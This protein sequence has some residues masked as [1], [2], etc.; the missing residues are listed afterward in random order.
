[1]RSLSL[2]RPRASALMLVIMF[3]FA[4][5]ALPHTLNGWS[6]L[7]DTQTVNRVVS[8]HDI[9]A[10][11]YI[12]VGDPTT[13]HNSSST[14][15]LAE[16]QL[17][18]SRLLLRFPMN[19]SA[20]DTIHEASIDLECTTNDVGTTR[21]VAYVASM[22]RMWNGSYA[23]WL[24]HENNQLWGSMGADGSADRGDWE[25]PVVLAS[26]GTLS[27]NVTSLAQSAARSNSS[28]LSVI[29]A[30]IGATYTCE[31]SESTNSSARPQL[32]LDTSS[33]AATSGG[34]V[35][36]D[37][38]ID[39]GAPWMESDFLLTPVTTPTLSYDSNT[40]QDVEIQ[41][42][43]AEDWRSST[44]K[45]WHFSTLWN[46]F[47]TSGATGS[48]ALPSSLELV[49]GTTMHMRVRSV[50]S[51]DQWGAWQ[52]TS[53]LL[54][55]LDVV[56]NGDGTATMTLT[57]SD[58][59]LEQDFM[60]DATVNEVSK[61]ITY[62][63]E[64]TTEASM[65]SSK[66]RLIHFRASLNQLGLHDNLTIVNAELELTRSSYSGDP[67]VS[68]HGMEESGL[69]VEN[70][71][72]WNIMG[73]NGYQWYDGG[74][75]NGTATV[76]LVDGNQSSDT[77]TFDLDHA[78][79][80]YLDGG[81]DDPLDL[82]IAVRGKYESYTNAEGIIFHSAET[83][84][85]GSEPSFSI[86]YEWGSG[87]PPA[88]VSLTAPADGL[89]I[90]N[91]TGHNLSANTQPSLNWSQP[92]SGDDL[93]FELATDEDFR[94]REMRVDTRVDNDFSPSDGILNMTGANTLEVGNMYFWRMATVDA[95]GHYGSW[96]SS[97]FLIS[98]LQST[99]LGGDRYEFRL[100]HGNGS[101]DN[102]Y[103]AC[104]DTYIDS[105]ATSDNFDGDTEMT[106][107]YNAMGGEI[108][109]LVGCNLVSNLLPN[110][111]AVESAHL[112]LTLTSS[113]FGTPTIA[114][115]ESSQN[116]WNAEDATWSSYDGSNSWD[117]AGAKGTERGSLL[118]S[119]SVG[120]SYNEG[121]VVDW[122]VTL[123]VQNAMR[124]D[125]R[126]DFIVGMLGVGSGGSRTAYFST[127]EDSSANRP[128]LTFVY[129]PG[130]DAVPNNP[131][132]LTPLNGSW[133]L[134]SGVDLTPVT[135]PELQWNF[136]GNMSIGGYLVQLDK[137]SDFASVDAVT[138]AS[139]NDGGFDVTNLTF[140][141]GTD[142][143]T[144][145]TWYWRV[146]AISTTNQIGN[147]S[148]TFHFQVPD[149][150][151]VVFNSTKAS[152]EIEHH[153]ALP[154][155]NIPHFTDT[156]VMENG[157]GA[158]STHEN[159][160]T[161]SIGETS[162]GYQ[163][164]ALL[165][166]PLSDIPQPS[167]ARVTDAE[168]SVFAEYGS[169]VGETVAAR[170]I[171]RNWT[172]SANASTYDGTN[173]WS[174]LGGRGIGT[175]I[176]NFVD[177]VDSVSDGW[178]D[179]DITEAVQAALANGQNHVSIMLYTSSQTTDLI[180]IT[181]TEGSAS[182]RPYMTLTWEDGVVATPTVS[183]VNTGPANGA[184]V[185][186]TSSHALIA[187]RTPTFSWTYSGTTPSSAWR[188]FLQADAN[189]DM[190]GLYVFDS[191]V[192]TTSFDLT[193][194]TFTPASDITFAQEIR[195]MVQPVNNGMLGPRSASTN[196]YLPSDLGEEINATH[197]SLSIQEGGFVPSLS[198]PSVTQDTYLDSGTT[199]SNVGSSSSLYVGLSSV[200]TS[201][202]NL[203]STSLISID[204]S[205]LPMPSVYE[206]VDA[207]L[208][209]NAITA[210]QNT[211][212]T[213]SAMVSGWTESSTW[214]YPA[215]NTTAWLG[216]GAFH[217]ADADAPFNEGIWVNAT[218]VA[219][220]NVTALLQH[221]LSSGQSELN[222]I[223]QPEDI[224]GNPGRV[225][226]ASSEASTISVRPRLNITYS[227][228]T[229][230]TASSPTN[231][232]PL[233]G[234]TLWDTTKPR[235]SGQNESDYNWS[236]SYSNQT[237][238]VACA[239]Y[240]ARMVDGLECYSIG[241]VEDGDVENMSFDAASL[242]LTVENQSKGDF[243]T[244]WR[245]RA[246]Q[247][248]RI[249]EW[250]SIYKFRIPE[251]QGSDD[252]N[253]NHT[254]NLSRGSIFDT[255]G[256]LPSIP[257]VE[258]DSNSS[259]NKGSA[260]SMVLGNNGLG[261]GE[262]RIL[263]E[264]DLTNLPWPSA[265]T[266]TQMMLKL[267][268]TSVG[269]TASTTIGVYPCSSFSESTVVWAN[270]P[271]CS[272]TEI[273]RSTL[274][275]SSPVGWM[276]WDIT[277]LAQSNLANGN[278][279]M[280]FMLQRIGTTGSSH[281]F[282]T[283]D[284]V[285]SI[286]HPHIVF[287]YVDNVNGIVPPAQPMLITP[288]DGQVLYDEDGGLLYPSTQ[289]VLTWSPVSGAT[290]YIVTIANE[291]G[292]YKYKSWEDSE[293]TNTTF[294]FDVNLTAGQM[295]TWWVQGVNQTIP[296]PS[297]ARWSFAVGDPNHVNNN[298]YTFTYTMQ[299]GNE[300]PAYGHTNIQ[301]TSLVSEYPDT[302]FVGDGTMATGTY[303][304]TLFADECRLTIGLNAAQVPFP[305][306]QQ[307][308][309]AS[310]GLYVEDWTTAAGATSISFSVYPLLGTTWTQTSA[311]W[312]GT[313]GGLLWGAP[314]LQAG[315][316]Y[317]DAVS[318]T[319][320]NTNTPGWLWFDIS[321][322]GMTISSQQAW[323]IIATPNNGYAHASFYSSDATVQS[324]RP[325]ILFNT[326]NI[327]TLSITPTG[328]VT[329]DADTTVNFNSVAYDHLSMVQ[330]PPVEWFTTSGSIG[331]NGLFTPTAAGV[332]TVSAC[333]GLV[334]GEQNVTVTPGAPDE[335]LVT[336]VTATITADETLTITASMVDQHGNPVPGEAITFTP[337]NGSMSAVMP[338]V[339]Q[340]YA[341]GTHVVRVQHTSSGEF[342][343][344]S[345]TVNPGA[346]DRFD[347]SGCAGT[348]PAGVWCDITAD[349]YDQFDN[350]LDIS[351]AGNLTWTT[352][353]GNYSEMNQQYFPDHVG[354]W[355][356]NLSSVSGAAASL[357]ITVGHGQIAY[358]ELNVSATSITADDRVYI[359]TTRV[360]V[361]GN[362]L[363]VVL[364]AD[365]WT[366]IADGQLNPGAPAIWDP[367]GQG[368]KVLEARYETTLASVT[369]TVTKGAIQTLRLEVDDVISTWQHFDL[370]ADE[371]L[372]AEV[373]AID[374]KGNQWSIL[375][376]WSLTHPTMGD[377][378]NF[379]EVLVGDATTFTPY[380]ASEDHYTLTASFDDG[381]KVHAVSIN[382]TVDHGFL[383]TVSIRGTANNPDATTGAVF[384]MTA[385]YAVDFLSD[386]YDADN[387][388]IDAETLTWL[389]VN[390]ATGQTKDITTDLLLNDMRWEATTVGEWTIQAYSISGT[391]F[392]ISDSI[393][394]TVLHGVAVTVAAD[395]SVTTPTA[396][397]RV[398]ILVTGTDSDG[399]QFAQNV[400]WTENGGTVPTLNII[401][402]TDG[403]YSYDAEVAG[404]HTL[405]YAAGGATST[406]EITV[407]AQ[408]TVARLEVNLSRT[409]LEQL[410]SLDISIRAFDAFDNE[411]D[412]P[413]SVKVD[414]T[415]R[416]TARMVASNEWTVTTLDD[417]PQTITISVG[418]V[419][420]NEE[421]NVVG[422]F[423]GFFEAGGTLYYVGA[424]LLALVAVVLLVLL[425]MFMRSGVDDD[426]DDE[427]DDDDD[428][429][430]S[431]PSGPAP[432]PSGPAP[433]PSGPAPGPS[434]PAPGPSGP[435]A[436]AEEKE[437]EEEEALETSFD[438]DGTEWWEDEDGTWWYREQGVEEWQ[439][440][441][442]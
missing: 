258:I 351:A 192:N 155:L 64:A 20:S 201:N 416:G 248:T 319:V 302:N 229:P 127:A 138:Y 9:H 360:D 399:N 378:S 123:A 435:P 117:T 189:N 377:S 81:D 260:T 241:E 163:A 286:F 219:S 12:T 397:D 49:N 58:T 218:G 402:T 204:F 137:Q 85:S 184:L 411:I 36:P 334:C 8:T 243:W 208:D 47:S 304:G 393:T 353:N 40:G 274:T 295:F 350:P 157:T 410:E 217:S 5:L 10:D 19:F 100:K 328:T 169:V 24:A 7:E 359:N 18:D 144:G 133:S 63:D 113:T 166:I 116:N 120:S 434:G 48:Y 95:D 121:D 362:R 43:N 428:G 39:D 256:L 222:I 382:M 281:T 346:P 146:R 323:V 440:Y 421:I 57:P 215:G 364:P 376:N 56:D 345:V 234:S 147:W 103:P 279:T 392:N 89:A 223:L 72:T 300:I 226:F 35:S 44:D 271:T 27:L 249:G 331:S 329:T 93:L 342:V 199:Q 235:P 262:S 209:L 135:R 174:S 104:M 225:Q 190:A 205:N 131:T 320:Y 424:A 75:S 442:E 408:N 101:L 202:T 77:F 45:E 92:S 349:L 94:L 82:L 130:S 38:P 54:P 159:D 162:S 246:E 211:F 30:S 31:M 422:N 21:M 59:G 186:D 317:G 339:F 109:A 354:V 357:M 431:G 338:N 432:G 98:Q 55:T 15:V 257:D 253:G 414:A 239:A 14:G 62:G 221:A 70:E 148:N 80:N 412:V 206:V 433:G 384:E 406:L 388:R 203:R 29:V 195:W 398:D 156:Y 276:E 23:T 344:V 167:G 242:T 158:D 366:R 289:P 168:L 165:R 278:T 197:A 310:L 363:P 417:G 326:T 78:V 438:D 335:L 386:L 374:A 341:V 182:E 238:W 314:G 102:Q 118:D 53:F 409:S 282:Y 65:T 198:Y 207:S 52:E 292:V 306:Y 232:N 413:G 290:G 268:Q 308:H 358:L 407:S 322:P 264:F 441:T 51:N 214:A 34:S 365:N 216:V 294:R 250:S 132:P 252:G 119:V 237:N 88:S 220:F 288:G 140:T 372:E 171:L 73:A 285:N 284:F 371:T 142:L 316:D 228:D 356:L 415:G 404:L 145:L 136:S 272:T 96:V 200:S 32:T 291:T 426:W 191:R 230:W 247:G 67:V 125:R 178:M 403:T 60:Q 396:G 16:G 213:A 267:Y 71:I 380:F 318:T 17:T 265:I 233:D 391:G 293:I 106:V 373:F 337:T 66:E 194:L 176:G 429:R 105:S 367:V 389:E 394:I 164:A 244:Y 97:S 418:A 303:C 87:T 91:Q 196:F 385:D 370:T 430:P 263:M 387:N 299:T 177:L 420:V 383:H 74:R 4:D 11:T 180:T 83:T 297:S 296:G 13:T 183:G 210:Y 379:L 236:A 128:E 212:I 327:T 400:V 149:L 112:Q 332:H 188:V 99:W 245:V 287:D 273:T 129:V 301:D 187:D 152:V 224:S 172:T 423:K 153:G 108:T 333:F 259:V 347:L 173:N 69:W 3:L 255:T 227:T 160:T 401:T 427:D 425:V 181:S 419:R 151:T 86:T 315:L 37:L 309:S 312:N 325:K 185:W 1:M 369:I 436:E 343:D 283:S 352:T 277:S 405:V 336:P 240:D 179:F 254:L 25:P 305:I 26:N 84:S 161:L 150:T 50:D 368:S 122:N 330:S 41:L 261:T 355:W 313:T 68:V 311:T 61:T 193:N 324:Y 251:D 321:T 361:R 170:P 33:G 154:A 231:L 110:G 143:D 270:A 42:S 395:A 90:W 390:E 79:Q 107:D 139:W 22:Q 175:D 126:V 381:T 269:G 2:R 275:L 115:W 437:P 124:E 375:A 439:E 134:G 28:Y 76:A 348:V 114:A 141:P 340:P 298:D 6:E 307:V 280:T 111:Y 46:S 266:P